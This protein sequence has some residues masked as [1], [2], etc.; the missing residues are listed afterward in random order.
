MHYRLT[1]FNAPT[2]TGWRRR[3]DTLYTRPHGQR[4]VTEG[5]TKEEATSGSNFRG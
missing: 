3:A 1:Y 2:T 4:D 5:E